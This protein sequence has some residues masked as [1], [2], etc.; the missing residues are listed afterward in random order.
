VIAF[1]VRGEKYPKS[2]RDPAAGVVFKFTQ[3]LIV[4]EEVIDLVIDAFGIA[5]AATSSALAPTLAEPALKP[6]R[7]K[8]RLKRKEIV[9]DDEDDEYMETTKNPK[10]DKKLKRANMAKQVSCNI[11]DGDD[12]DDDGDGNDSPDHLTSLS[13]RMISELSLT[14]AFH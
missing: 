13:L 10:M 8:P 11:S 3:M 2:D 12:D 6:T 9:S 5:T 7:A 1:S 14:A 4:E